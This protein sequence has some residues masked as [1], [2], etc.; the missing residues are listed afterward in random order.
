M[1][2]AIDVPPA[3]RRWHSDPIREFFPALRGLTHSICPR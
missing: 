3:N 1:A 2:A